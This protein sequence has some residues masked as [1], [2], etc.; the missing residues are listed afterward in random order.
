MASRG[1]PYRCTFCF[2][3]FFAELPEDKK[4]K[5]KY[6]RLRSV[7]HVMDELIEAKNRYKNIRYMDFQDD[8]FTTSKE[9]LQE[10][11]PRYKKEIDTA[12]SMPYSP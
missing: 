10:F 5:G 1:C 7:E 12:L 9:W 2:N 11:L 8:V 3:N 4:T 6:V